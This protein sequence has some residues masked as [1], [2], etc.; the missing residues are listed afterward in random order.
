MAEMEKEKFTGSDVGILKIEVNNDGEYIA[1]SAD[2]TAL[3][4]R[5][6]AG[7]IHI[8]EMSDATA[9]KIGEIEKQY[10]GQDGFRADMDRIT[11]ISRE[12]VAFSK[13]A[14]EVV[15]GIFGEGTI[16]KLFRDTYK[17]IPDFLPS[18]PL[19]TDFFEQITPYMEKLFDRKLSVQK[20]LSKTRMEKYQPQ[21]HKKPAGK[22]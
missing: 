12:N 14:V 3:F 4:D 5:F 13:E 8:A 20:Q 2:D 6:A 16:K 21:D 18:A 15:D 7:L 11:A 17:E 22:K 1:L 9:K 10:D 19:F